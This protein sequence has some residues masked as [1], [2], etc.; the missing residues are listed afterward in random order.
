MRFIIS[1]LGI[2]E[3]M[4]L[5][6]INK[7]V[8]EI[9]KPNYDLS[10][11]LSLDSSELEVVLRPST[12]QHRFQTVLKNTSLPPH[13]LAFFSNVTELHEY[14]QDETMVRSDLVEGQILIKISF[15]VKGKMVEKEVAL[16]LE[17]VDSDEKES[18]GDSI[19]Q[20]KA[21]LQ[22]E[23]EELKARL[24]RAERTMQAYE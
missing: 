15:Q 19:Q 6:K 4:Y 9:K 22:R 18:I 10:T 1:R 5:P 16:Q 12:H 24:E 11:T 21:E 7:R 14:L 13:L 8:N 20:V 3:R 17:R 2:P 23:N